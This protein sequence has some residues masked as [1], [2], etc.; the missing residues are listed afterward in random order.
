MRDRLT[1]RI[2]A[3]ELRVYVPTLIHAERIRQI[4]NSRGEQ[5]AIDIIRQ[6]VAA[7]K[8]KLLPLSAQDAETVADVWLALKA[9][10]VTGDY[11]QT[12]KF[13][14]VLCAIARS[15]NY[16]LITDDQG[17]HFEVVSSRMNTTQLENWL[18]QTEGG[19]EALPLFG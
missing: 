10:E 2:S 11:W 15:R 17:Q 12:H 19:P 16:T 5:F 1:H 4:A 9:R 18:N 13:D 3:G 8:F 6:Q 7:S 14:I